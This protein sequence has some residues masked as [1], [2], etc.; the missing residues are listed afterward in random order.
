[1]AN[2]KLTTYKAKRDFKQT[3][4]ERSAGRQILQS[5]SLRH[6]ET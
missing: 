5:S 2:A 3:Q 1:M 4:A 6:S